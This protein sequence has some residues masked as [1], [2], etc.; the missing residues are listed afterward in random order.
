MECAE[1]GRKRGLCECDCL[2]N[3]A[4][5]FQNLSDTTTGRGVQNDRFDGR[6]DVRRL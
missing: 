6:S 4:F 3:E 2:N 5:F 1:M